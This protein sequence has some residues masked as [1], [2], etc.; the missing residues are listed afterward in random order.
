MVLA[1]R[2]TRCGEVRTAQSPACEG[3]RRRSGLFPKCGLFFDSHTKR[4]GFSLAFSLV[5]HNE[6]EEA[7]CS[8]SDHSLVWNFLCNVN[9][10]EVEVESRKH[11]TCSM[12]MVKQ[13]TQH[14]VH[15]VP[16]PVTYLSKSEAILEVDGDQ[17]PANEKI[18]A[19]ST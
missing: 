15:N 16:S 1:G 7:I 5:S 14:F 11:A 10:Q 6:L 9:R 17:Q 19:A 12:F 4:D 13:G 18:E 2:D 8:S 3:L